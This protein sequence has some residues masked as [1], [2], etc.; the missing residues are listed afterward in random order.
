MFK[1]FLPS[2]IFIKRFIAIVLLFLIVFLIVKFIKN[3]KNNP[4]ANSG[5]P[6]E[7]ITIR[8]LIENDRDSDGIADWE[9]SLWGTDPNKT[10]TDDNGQDDFK[11]IEQ[12]KLALKKNSVADDEI[13]E[14]ETSELSK[15]I[16]ATIASLKQ[17]GNLNSETI[18]S[19]A[20]TINEKVNNAQY[21]ENHFVSTDI[22]VV[23]QT[24][25]VYAK[26]ITAWMDQNSGKEIG[27]ELVYL[28]KY[29]NEASLDSLQKIEDIGIAY[30]ELADSL[31][32]IESTSEASII[33]LQLANSAYK[34]SVACI[35]ISSIDDNP[36][37]GVVG[38]SQYKN[39]LDELEEN[40]TKLETFI[41]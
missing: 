5:K 27:T 25:Q 40:F 1:K 35:N 13:P 26:K 22:K 31:I 41:K 19:L 33:Q 10:D 12:K 36:L 17:S 18:G 29:F 15:E 39:N 9:E 24:K 4:S 14:N 3:S 37:I 28:E 34:I 38:V 11:Y 30:R 32:K 20:D 7:T 2:N 6:V 21:L 23:A 8:D 16:F